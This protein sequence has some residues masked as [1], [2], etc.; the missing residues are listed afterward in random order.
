MGYLLVFMMGFLLSGIWFGCHIFVQKWF[1]KGKMAGI[2]M[3]LPLISAFVPT[4][5]VFAT[6]GKAALHT[7]LSGNWMVWGI[8]AGITVGITCLIK[9]RLGH[10]EQN[11]RPEYNLFL[12]CVEAACMEIPQRVMMQT[13]LCLLLL[14][15]GLPLMMGIIL[16]AGVWGLSIIVQAVLLK[17]HDWYE[18]SIDVLASIV[19]S[20]GSGYVYFT[21]EIIVIPMIMHALERFIVTKAAERGG[22]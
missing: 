14:W 13:F 9:I 7:G 6:A 5:I 22:N 20:L 3:F 2:E 16:N 8:T 21:S 4:G 1:V 12:K 18:I 15:K 10:I 17:Q 19:F 11:H